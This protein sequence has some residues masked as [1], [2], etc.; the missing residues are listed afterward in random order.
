MELRSFVVLH[1]QA[2]RRQRE[3]LASQ[4]VASISQEETPDSQQNLKLVTNAWVLADSTG[5]GKT[6]G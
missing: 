5:G 6:S 2:Q 3:S 4:E 1:A